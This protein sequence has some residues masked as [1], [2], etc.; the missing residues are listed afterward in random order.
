MP[1]G[2]SLYDEARLQGRLWTPDLARPVF[3]Y[4]ASDLSTIETVSGGVSVWR[5]KGPNRIHLAQTDSARRPTL[6]ITEGMQS[7]VYDGSNDQ[8]Q[9]TSIAAMFSQPQTYLYLVS[10]TSFATAYNTFF[11]SWT[12]SLRGVA[13]F[14]K[15]NGRSAAYIGDQSY[16]GTGAATYAV[17]QVFLYACTHGS[18]IFTSWKNGVVDRS[19]TNTPSQSSL[20]GNPFYLGAGPVFNRW[21][22]WTIREA[23]CVAS[24]VNYD[25]QRLEGA[26][27]WKRG[28]QALLPASHPFANRPPLIGD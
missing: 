14:I 16:D 27:L 12:S 17:N 25:R 13:H 10:S 8:M 23:I 2:V 24:S 1:R 4:D 28:L 5:D 26:M 22:P 7:V 21:T 20:A 19:G 3:W 9:G 6:T 18:G 11:D 15:S